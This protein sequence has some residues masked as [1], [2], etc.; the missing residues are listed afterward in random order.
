[1]TGKMG[2]KCLKVTISSKKD[3]LEHKYRYFVRFLDKLTLKDLYLKLY[4]CIIL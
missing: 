3:M 4:Y 1:M 2:R